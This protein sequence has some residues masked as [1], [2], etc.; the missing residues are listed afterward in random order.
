LTLIKKN[1]IIYIERNEKRKWE[2]YVKKTRIYW[3]CR[4]KFNVKN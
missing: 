3:F 4:R 1:D 2:Y